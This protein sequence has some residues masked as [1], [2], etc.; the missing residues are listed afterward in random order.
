MGTGETERLWQADGHSGVFDYAL[1]SCLGFEL[2]LL[3]HTNL[4][5]EVLKSL[6]YWH[7]PYWHGKEVYFCICSPCVGLIKEKSNLRRA[8]SRLPGLNTHGCAVRARLRGAPTLV[9]VT[10]GTAAEAQTGYQ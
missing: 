10:S 1:K 6:P 5:S 3:F 8:P 2:D 9:P 7:L 4:P